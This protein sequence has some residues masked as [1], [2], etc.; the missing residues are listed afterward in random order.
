[1]GG[2][3]EIKPPSLAEQDSGT[4]NNYYR[5]HTDKE[6]ANLYP[7]TP[8]MAAGISNRIWTIEDIVRLVDQYI[9]LL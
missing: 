9:S 3:G 7:T 5:S 4:W 1:M 6:P 2:G 8:A